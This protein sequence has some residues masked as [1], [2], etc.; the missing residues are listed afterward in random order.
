MPRPRFLGNLDR[1]HSLEGLQ[2]KMPKRNFK[3][4]DE[5][6]TTDH[7][8]FGAF[9]TM[10][11]DARQATKS[12]KKKAR[13]KKKKKERIVTKQRWFAQVKRVQCY[14]GLRPR[15][16]FMLA[17][18]P[19]IDLDL[20]SR[21][22]DEAWQAYEIAQCLNLPDVDLTQSA[23]YLFYGNVVFVSVDVE[24]YEK[25]SRSVTEIGISSLDTLDLLDLPPG[26]LGK[27][28]T[29]RIHSRHFRIKETAHLKNSM[30]VAGCGDKF[31]AEF[32]VSEWVSIKD[33]PKAIATCFRPPFASKNA[34][35][36]S[37]EI[38][39]VE[40]SIEG[41]LSDSVDDCNESPQKRN[42]ILVGH[43]VK[44]DIEYLRKIGYDIANLGNL[45]EPVDTADLYRAWQ[46][47]QNPP[48]LGSILLSLGITGWNLH[49][50][51]SQTDRMSS[52]ICCLGPTRY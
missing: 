8:S 52:S 43:D 7:R 18:D 4:M 11:E 6:E 42:V 3:E 24:A 45:A 26:E 23:P 9:K 35:N 40:P 39:R 27:L 5:D 15:Q 16:V 37:S 47:E 28:W 32:G 13:K 12:Q 25:G 30:F 33:A 51:V 44:N 2:A 34:K 50:A 31:E 36:D 21:H 46:H 19:A 14:L 17:P 38:Q 1:D 22:S 10:M 49:N 41:H 48:K 29:K 20:D